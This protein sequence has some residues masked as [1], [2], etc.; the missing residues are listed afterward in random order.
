MSP[1]WIFFDLRVME[2][3]VTTGAIRRAC[4][5]PVKMSPLTNQ[6]PAFHSMNLPTPGSPGVFHLVL[7]T[8]SSWLPWGTVAKPLVSPLTPAPHKQ[9]LPKENF[10]N[11][12]EVHLTH[13]MAQ[14]CPF[15]VTTN[16][17]CYTR[18]PAAAE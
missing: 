2:V 9:Q 12:M 6:H 11:Q 3:V 7:T 13:Q 8:K 15:R 4:K 10:T 18:T 5:A 16:Q 17:W 14:C 1:F